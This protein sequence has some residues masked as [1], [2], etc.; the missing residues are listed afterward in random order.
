MPISQ[1]L[2]LWEIS[3]KVIGYKNKRG[4]HQSRHEMNPNILS[5]EKHEIFDDDD[6]DD[7]DD[8]D[9]NDDGDDHDDD[10]N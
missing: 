6:N 5:K 4:K 1:V 9:D 2:S 10:Q 7:D 3:M 8:D